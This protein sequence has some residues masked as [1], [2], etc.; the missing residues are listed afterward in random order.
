MLTV[1]VISDTHGLLREE[2]LTALAGSDLILHAGDVGGRAILEGLREIAPVHAVR[3]NTDRDEWGQ[4]LPFTELVPLAS[5][6]AEAVAADAPLAYV[7]HDIDDLDL[8]PA[9][10]GVKVV[11]YG[12]THRPSIEWRDG[13]LYF[14]PGAAGQRRFSLPVSVGR[15]T[16]S[17]GEI[18][19][20]VV[21]LGL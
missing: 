2:A 14:N 13:V 16:V 10:A 9:A 19:V 1:G 17:D 5:A 18:Q 11:V 12:H 15:L 4:A 7:I 6:R 3:G 8:E 20:E 21:E